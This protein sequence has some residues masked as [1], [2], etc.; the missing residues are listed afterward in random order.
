MS[1]GYSFK[2]ELIRGSSVTIGAS[3]TN[4]VVSNVFRITAS[5]SL[6]FLAKL[7]STTTTSTTGITAKLQESYDGSTWEDVGN[8]AQVTITTNGTWEISLIA[9]DSSDAAQ[10]PLWPL[11]RLVVS[12]GADD[13]VTITECWISRR[14]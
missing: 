3:A 11:G 2:N 7:K 9:T 1:D 8:R 14:T 13:A 5:D 10:L 6:Y 4:T 12:T